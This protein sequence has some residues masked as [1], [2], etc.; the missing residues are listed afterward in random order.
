MDNQCPVCITGILEYMGSLGDL[1]WFR[2]CNCG[3]EISS[4]IDM[5]DE[6]ENE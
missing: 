6:D 1:A 3:A 2:C 4:K 5:T